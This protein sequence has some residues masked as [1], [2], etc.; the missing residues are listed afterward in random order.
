VMS[1]ILPALVEGRRRRSVME[2]VSL[3]VWACQRP[4]RRPGAVSRPKAA[5]VA[6]DAPSVRATMATPGRPAI[7]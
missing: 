1:W 5:A 7:G 4:E 6:I 3:D 2:R